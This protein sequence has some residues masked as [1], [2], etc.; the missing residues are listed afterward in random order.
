MLNKLIALGLFLGLAVGLGAA[1]TDS[2]L[3]HAIARESAPL[4]KL[5]I[6]AIKM[7]VI[8]LVVSVIFAS[9]AR[10]GNVRKALFRLTRSQRRQTGLSCR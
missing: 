5:F 2:E 7:I 8:P 6:N 1:A 9:V 10:L 4:G 3:L